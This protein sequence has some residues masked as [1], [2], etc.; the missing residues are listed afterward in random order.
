MLTWTIS[1]ATYS[2]TNVSENEM[3]SYVP[4]DAID[5][6]VNTAKNFDGGPD[7]M[8]SAGWRDVPVSAGLTDGPTHPATVN[9]C[10]VSLQI[11]ALTRS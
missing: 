4:E 3:G 10:C 2:F 1:I 8:R 5:S 11:S 7:I 6:H 9:I